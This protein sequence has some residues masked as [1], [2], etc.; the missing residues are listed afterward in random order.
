MDNIYSMTSNYKIISRNI[1]FEKKVGL[2][3]IC[4]DIIIE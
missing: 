2:C 4:I 1:L 3:E